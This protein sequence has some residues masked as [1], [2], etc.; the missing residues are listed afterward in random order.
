M[1]KENERERAKGRKGGD[2]AIVF[3]EKWFILF[4]VFPLLSRFFLFPHF[5]WPRLFILWPN[6]IMG[7]IK[8]A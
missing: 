8:W 4:N 2:E 3:V 7:G 5:I 1:E 6:K